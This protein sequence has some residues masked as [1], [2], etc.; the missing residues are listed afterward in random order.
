MSRQHT[1][2][3]G[4]R[5]EPKLAEDLLP[6]AFAGLIIKRDGLSH[7]EHRVNHANTGVLV[8]ANRRR[9]P[10]NNSVQKLTGVCGKLTEKK[11]P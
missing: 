8:S 9:Y 4:T 3:I 10:E 1:S 11:S 7:G 2:N 5:S 6:S